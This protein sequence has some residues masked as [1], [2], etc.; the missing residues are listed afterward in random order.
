MVIRR[1]KH[2]TA[3]ENIASQTI[4]DFRLMFECMLLCCLCGGIC[5]FG[6]PVIV[7]QLDVGACSRLYVTDNFYIAM[8]SDIICAQYDMHMCDCIP[9]ANGHYRT[10]YKHGS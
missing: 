1:V 3:R 9:H 10:A 6:T 4:D 5:A 7:Y 8:S 2:R